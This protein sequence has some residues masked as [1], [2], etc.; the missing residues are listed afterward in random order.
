MSG[1]AGRRSIT[2]KLILAA[3][4]VNMAGLGA[5]IFLLDR[6][7]KESLYDLATDAWVIQT[8]QIATAAAGGVKWKKADVVAESWAAYVDNEDK[9]L[10]RA[11]AFDAE[12]KAIADFTAEGVQAEP[13]DA[14]LQRLVSGSP[15]DIVVAP[16]D[17]NVLMIAPAGRTSDGKALGH[18]G[19]VWNTAHV[20][21]ARS[22]LSFGSAVVQ[23][24]SA[25]LLVALLFVSIRLV[26]GRPLG[27]ITARI[28]KLSDGD[29]ESGVSY[30]DRGD[31]VGV[32]ARA[33]EGF[34]AASV[35]KLASDRELEAQRRLIEDERDQNDSARA[36]ATKLQAAIVKLI[37]AALERLAEGDLTARLE[38]DFP[39]EYR[40]L[41][42]DFNLAMDRLQEAMQQIVS[43]G[44]QL[45]VGTGEIRKAADEL[46]RRSELQAATI[47]ETV[48]A[49]G[50]IT[51][52]V[53]A[54]AAGAGEA[55]G[56]V[57]EM[58]SD[59]GRSDE[60]VGQAI[61]A[62]DAIEKSS[63][64]IT[65][66]IGVIDEIA[67]Q[68]NL[69]ALNA[70]VE[71]A[72]AGEAG[73]GFA[74]VAQEVRSLAQRS[75][76]AAR[77]IK[78][79]I[80]SSAAQVKTGAK[81]VAE[82]GDFIG[83]IASKVDSVNGIVADIARGAEEQANTLR[84]INS[85][86]SGIDTATQQGAAMAQ[87]FTSTSRNLAEDGEELTRLMAH[88]RSGSPSERS[89]PE[90]AR[91]APARAAPQRMARPMTQGA[92]ALAV[93]ADADAWEEF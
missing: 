47:E 72:R 50:E 83:R 25:L 74:V 51:R 69:L 81:L 62:M 78:Q 8:G 29:L 14:E 3:L 82:T 23:M 53:S 21:D 38:A 20:A 22:A 35:D 48:A 30:Q 12:G 55:R 68:T 16:F 52:S 63:G 60:V 57:S 58:A 64:E 71:A 24:L 17:G 40:K 59:A 39:P 89:R 66:I 10:S 49:V 67:F 85:A 43:T 86:M 88:F 76:D 33:L 65:K 45:E 91:P 19:V 28:E 32:I 2:I 34:R 87:E 7:A 5:S 79:L 4:L 80:Q 31:E 27:A 9:I 18:V 70:G 41:K 46:A 73:R 44:R 37:G 36:G 6:T 56:A 92:T 54:T 93:S 77:E 15:Q 42:E 90:P 13:L 84:G 1:V 26:V 11:I 75:A 61:E